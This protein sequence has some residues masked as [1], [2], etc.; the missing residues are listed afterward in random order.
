MRFTFQI[1]IGLLIVSLFNCKSEIKS[2]AHNEHKQVKKTEIDKNPYFG[3]RSK[4]MTITPEQLQLQLDSDKELYGIVM[5]WNMGDAIVT[6][7][8]FKT[9]DASVYLST[10]QMFIGGYTHDS[11]I[12]AAKRFVNVGKKYLKMAIIT[13]DQNPTNE[14]KVNFYLLTKSGRYYLEE[15][16]TL[17]EN[18]NSAIT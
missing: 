9:G 12:D 13:E 14:N 8:S 1:I 10:G 15:E 6:V 16:M 3:L 11:I 18:N 17:I 7:V 5:D 4:A 2:E